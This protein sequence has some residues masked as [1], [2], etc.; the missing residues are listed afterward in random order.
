MKNVTSQLTSCTRCRPLLFPPPHEPFPHEPHEND[1]ANDKVWTHP[2]ERRGR[3]GGKICGVIDESRKSSKA[4][5]ER[6]IIYFRDKNVVIAR[7][8]TKHLYGT[9]HFPV[10]AL[11]ATLGK[12]RLAL[13]FTP[14]Q[15]C[16]GMGPCWWHEL[17]IGQV[18]RC[19]WLTHPRN[20]VMIGSS[21]KMLN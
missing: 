14:L 16:C 13:I 12:S 1:V 11:Y 2:A 17:W 18:L 5:N 4:I 10:P 8:A 3:Q 9:R 20:V 19:Y 15:L 7:F 21:N 6:E